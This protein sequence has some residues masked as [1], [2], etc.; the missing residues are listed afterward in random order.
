[1]TEF[2]IGRFGVIAVSIIISAVVIGCS[3]LVMDRHSSR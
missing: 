1:M 2:F 3:R